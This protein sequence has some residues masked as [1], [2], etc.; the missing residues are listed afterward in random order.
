MNNDI[1]LFMSLYVSNEPKRIQSVADLPKF[2]VLEIEVKL[3]SL[4]LTGV[5]V[6]EGSFFILW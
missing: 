1:D 2:K 6:N 3:H 4:S 5:L